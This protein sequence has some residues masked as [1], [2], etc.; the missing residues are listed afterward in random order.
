VGAFGDIIFKSSFEGTHIVVSNAA[1]S[2]PGTLRQALLD[3]QDNDIIT[4]DPA[5][6]PPAAPVTISITS[7]LE[8]I[9]D[10]HLVLDASNAGVVL[11]GSLLPDEWL[12][13]LAM[14]SC[15]GATIRGLRIANFPGPG[16]YVS[17]DARNN[18]IGGDRNIGA[19]PFGQGNQLIHNS[20]GVF[21]ATSGT[22]R[23]IIKGNL[24]GTDIAGIAQL[25]NELNG[26]RIDGA[27]GNTIGPDNIIAYNGESGVHLSGPNT[28]NNTITRNSIWGHA[29][30]GIHSN[31]ASHS[32]ITGNI[33]G[34][35][36]S[37]IFLCCVT[38]GRNSVRD[39]IIGADV[40]G[41]NPL[42]NQVGIVIDRT[43]FN[44]IGTGN[45][46]AFNHKGI[47]FWGDSLFNTVTQNSI[48]DNLG[49]GIELISADDPRQYG[50]FIL[51]FD[52]H[53]GH[54]TGRTCSNCLVEIF[55]DSDEEGGTYEGQTTT[56]NMGFF[57]FSRA[58]AFTG[59]HLTTYATDA[60]GSTTVFSRPTRGIRRDLTP[61]VDNIL[62][63][64]WLQFSQ[65]RDLAD[66]RIGLNFGSGLWHSLAT[67]DNLLGDIT[68]LGAK[69]IETSIYE[70]EPPIDWSVSELVFPPEFDRFVDDLGEN[71]VTLNYMFLFW[72]KA[73]YAAGE[74]FITPR[75]KTESE[76]QKLLD[77]A[78][79]VVGHF[80]GRIPYYTIWNEPNNCSGSINN[81]IE[82]QD[83]INL[84]RQ[85]IPV[86]HEEDPEA[87]VVWAPYVLFFESELLLNVLRSDVVQLFDVISWHP[88]YDMPPDSE[89]FGDYYREYPSIIEEIKS[90][91]SASGF[92]GEYW[93]TEIMW[94]SKEN[95]SA[96]CE[97]SEIQDTD[98]QA[99]K[100]YARVV[101]T[102]LGLDVG[103]GVSGSVA[104]PKFTIPYL[105]LRNL[106]NVMAGISPIS[107]TVE[108]D[109]TA[110]NIKSY[111]FALPNGDS[112][113]A[114]WTDDAA[115]ENDPGV[116]GTLTF[117]DLS[118]QK[119]TATDVLYGFE[120]ELITETGN[121]NLVVRDL[122]VR[123]YPIILHLFH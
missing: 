52:L 57:E 24:I 16:I 3:A 75:F 84:V 46:I 10:N 95:C 101:V 114:L 43:S 60:D 107:I 15:Q 104:H 51:D 66:N 17:G 19:G 50:P 102:Q 54:L 9:D 48:R 94:N 111:G 62:S 39:N 121:G 96:W 4:F 35:N 113:L 116:N 89:M 29:H 20:D 78:R 34:G 70:M 38:E 25:G 49:P 115:V 109:S 91:A 82:P 86:I 106:N 77:Y 97:D 13:G 27:N 14:V 119:V 79:L 105:T 61:Q 59:P 18:V 53:A 8:P 90:T 63:K 76:I 98:E 112:L 23:N 110:T 72:D 44:V 58:T 7:P 99:A 45:I 81:C 55:S 80:K 83:Y 1:D 31:G 123:D 67:L 26:M 33:I 103:V 56:D 37:G 69:R 118:A 21:L 74:E 117:L 71:G 68:S 22:S 122:V 28:V 100:Y 73:G 36:G 32:L 92:Q 64:Q 42:G 6:F 5:V 11:D 93:G 30:D 47:T 65:S 85:L 88:L 12:A 41:E 120:Q 87:K 2:G 108:I 40:G